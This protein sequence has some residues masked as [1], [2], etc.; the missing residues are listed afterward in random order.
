MTLLPELVEIPEN[1]IGF[2]CQVFH[3]DP[4]IVKYDLF[5]WLPNGLVFKEFFLNKLDNLGFVNLGS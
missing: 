5:R 3:E 4:C 1:K 2:D